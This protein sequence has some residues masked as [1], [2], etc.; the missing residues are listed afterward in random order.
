MFNNSGDYESQAQNN[1]GDYSGRGCPPST[2]ASTSTDR[3]YTSP[4][5]QRDPRNRGGHSP[6]GSN[7]RMNGASPRREISNRSPKKRSQ[8]EKVIHSPSSRAHRQQMVK[9]LRNT[10]A[11]EKRMSKA[12]QVIDKISHIVNT[13]GHSLPMI[14]NR[15]K[16]QRK[17][18]N[19]RL[20]T[21]HQNPLQILINDPNI[22]SKDI[23]NTLRT[24]PKLATNYSELFNSKLF[25]ENLRLFEEGRPLIGEPEDEED[26]YSDEDFD[27]RMLGDD[28]DEE[29]GDV[30]MPPIDESHHLNY[31]EQEEAPQPRSNSN[32][33]GASHH[34]SSSLGHSGSNAVAPSSSTNGV[35]DHCT[36]RTKS[37]RSSSVHDCRDQTEKSVQG[38]NGDATS[39][40]EEMANKQDGTLLTAFDLHKKSI[41]LSSQSGNYLPRLS[42]RDKE[43]AY[44]TYCR[45]VPGKQCKFERWVGGGS[46][47]SANNLLADPNSMTLL[48]QADGKT[49]FV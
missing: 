16:L 36:H 5:R 27:D 29:E 39:R 6:R 17:Y 4:P 25:L 30:R 47:L 34:P 14:E 12:K 20:F 38:G 28:D 49:Y 43:E 41:Q 8:E 9:Q 33:T 42:I 2:A 23:N 18:N 22:S 11:H 32:G 3:R 21:Y 37:S 26:D 46:N 7:Q 19:G 13:T 45:P 24:H 10:K 15:G 44:N 48:D 31:D 35:H 40:I 1:Y